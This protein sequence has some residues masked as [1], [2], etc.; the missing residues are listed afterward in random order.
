MTWHVVTGGAGFIGANLVR[1]LCATGAKVF[2]VDNLSLG[3]RENLD[4]IAGVVFRKADVAD[5]AA[6]AEALRDVPD[7]PG[8]VWHLCAN[9]DIQKGVADPAIDLHDTFL[10]TFAVLAVMRARGWEVLHFASTSA[11]YGDHGTVAVTEAATTL[12]VSNYGAMKIGSE[13]LISAA[14]ESFL[15]TA[16]IFRFPNVIGLPATHG[17][18]LDFVRRLLADPTQLVVLGDG[19]Q[20]KPYVHVQ[21]LIDAMLFIRAHATGRL[22]IY[23]IGPPDD[24]IRVSEIA[25]L[26]R[27]RI[28]PGAGIAPDHAVGSGMCRAS[29]TTSRGWCNW[30]GHRNSVRPMP[31][32]AR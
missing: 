30:A 7:G 21:E 24:G 3:R 4:G 18:I 2:V 17:V 8:E 10:S 1:A 15:R 29:A 27:D 13:A 5:A 23:N 28:A 19:T 32:P 25:T 11:V 26:V 9:S 14:C 16:R 12:P 6:L 31:S 22:S 20:Q